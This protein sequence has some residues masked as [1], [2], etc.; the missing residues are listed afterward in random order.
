MPQAKNLTSS[1]A[2]VSEGGEAVKGKKKKKKSQD[3]HQSLKLRKQVTFTISEG[4]RLGDWQEIDLRMNMATQ[5]L[6]RSETQRALPSF[7]DKHSSS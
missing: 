4:G 1:K 6:I 5:V 7:D 2:R 3:H